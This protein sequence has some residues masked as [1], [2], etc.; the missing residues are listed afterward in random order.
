MVLR[1]QAV[2]PSTLRPLLEAAAGAPSSRNSQPWQLRVVDPQRL[3]LRADRT[4][5]L[6]RNDPRDREL[7]ISCGAALASIEVA[8][9]GQGLL[10]VVS[11]WPDPDDAD[12]VAVVHLE[13]GPEASRDDRD[14]AEA[15]SGRRTVRRPFLARPVVEGA[16]DDMALSAASFGL[17]LVLVDEGERALLAEL[18]AEGDRL[19]FRDRAWRRELAAGLQPR[20]RGEGLP[21]PATTVLLS[22]VVVANVDLGIRTGRNEAEL[23]R[24]APALIVLAS[25]GDDRS[26]WLDT[27]RCLQRMLLQGVTYGIQAGYLNSACQVPALRS[28]LRNLVTAGAHPQVVLRLGY[29]AARVGRARRRPLAEVVT[30]AAAGSF[31]ERP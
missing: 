27:G 22:R 10:P 5:S 17:C 9:R 23:V 13:A 26:D 1:A 18:V 7:V 14:L 15:L 19:Q 11:T 16:L 28:R 20:W 29:P 8:A 12:L 31:G 2:V 24:A 21:V 3:E 25:A 6:P 4:R 30:V